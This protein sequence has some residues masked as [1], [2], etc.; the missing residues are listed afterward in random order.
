[1]QALDLPVVLNVNPR[2]V[3]NKISEFHTLVTQHEVDLVCMSEGWERENLT[4]DQIIQLEDYSIIS[5]VHQR[6]GTGGRPAIIVNH[7]KYN[8]QN[9]T[10]KLINIPWGVEA[11]WCL[12]SPK[13]VTNN[14][15]VKKIAVASIYS[16]PNSRKKS[17]LLDH[18]S[19]SFNLLSSK[20]TDGLYFI[21]AGDTN[22]LKLDSILSLSPNMKQVVSQN[23]RLNPPAMLD[24]ILTT[25]S[26]FYQSPICLP[27]LDPD[28]LSNGSPSDHLMPLMKPISTLNNRPARTKRKVII[29]PLPES[30]LAEFRTWISKHSW[31]NVYNAVTAHSKAE[32]FQTELLE[33]LNKCLPE[34]MMTFSS[35]DQ[36]WMTPELKNLDRKRKR[37]FQKHRKSERWHFLNSKFEEK[38]NL[39]KSNYYKNMIED[40]KISN[41]GQWYSKFKRISSHDQHKGEIVNVEELSGLTD[42]QQADVIA[43]QYENVANQYSP[44]E[45]SDVDLPPIPEGSIPKIDPAH[46]YK[47]LS[48]IKTTTS[49]VKND[50]PAKV[51]KMFAADLAHPLADIISTS[52]VRGEFANLWKLE[53]VTPVPKVFPPLLCKDLRKISVFLNFSKITEQIVSEFLVADMK[54]KFEKTQFGNQK[55][56]GVQHYLLKLVHKILY[57]LDNNSKGEILAVIANLYDWRQAFD[58]QCPKLGLESFVRNGVR[59]AFLPLLRNYFQ[60]RKM[61][62]KWHGLVSEVRTLNGG[63]PQGGNFG[64]LEYLSQTN[65]N[66]DFVDQD[67]VFKYFDDASVLEIVNLISIG[68][69]SHNFKSQVASNIPTHNQFIPGNCLKSQ[70]YL[71]RISQWTDENKMQLNIGKSNAMLFNFTHN[72]QFTTSFSHSAGDINVIEDTKLLGTIITSDLKWS[73]NTEFLVKKA[74]ARM[75]LLHKIAEFSAP[76]EDMVTIYI[77]YIRSI[78]EQSC[79]VWH[80]SLTQ[81]NTEDLERVQKSALRI[82]LKENY[83]NYEEA[84]ETLM[85]AKL[86]DRREKLSL[87]F[88]KNCV[89]NELTSE[90]FPLNNNRNRDKF[91]VTHANTDRLKNSAVPYLQR[92]LNANQKNKEK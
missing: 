92:L 37:Q 82:I 41:P 23:T 40:L 26:K 18:L 28:P 36:P 49:T 30:G 4:L 20:Y 6:R 29:R 34:K 10:H 35:D 48:R 12:I 11:V 62:V 9:L 88:A 59:P 69:A 55:G 31:E 53:T 89:K 57:T 91:K 46:V 25:M 67:L 74:N 19:E 64:I 15:I 87:K 2:S 16:K 22:D 50:V 65:N 72:Y 66:F 58:L 27:P 75:R 5:N 83:T 13:H 84:L 43:N 44:L 14:S 39:V 71:E 90:L 33:T 80:S 1:M 85:L 52:I 32:I 68:L 54:E 38:C 3:Y 24:P 47:F 8:V 77:M 86:S 73:K 63:G 51:I 70:Q 61:V 56:T 78:L 81:E 76:V 79:T 17:V 7:K 42:Q 45:D 60:N 21:I